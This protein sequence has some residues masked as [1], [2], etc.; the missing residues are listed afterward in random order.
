MS[1]AEGSHYL[2]NHVELFQIELIPGNHGVRLET[3]LSLFA[4]FVNGF[5]NLLQLARRGIRDDLRPGFVSLTKRHCI[6]VTR[7]SISTQSLVGHFRDVGASPHDW[8]TCG[9]GSGGHTG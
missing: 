4:G 9:A 8:H 7:T 5:I 3:R 2:W 6:G 1:F